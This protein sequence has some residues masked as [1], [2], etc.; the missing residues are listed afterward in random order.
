MNKEYENKNR[1]GQNVRYQPE[2]LSLKG[3]YTIS[4]IS[5]TIG[6]VIVGILNLATPLQIITDRLAHLSRQTGPF[7]LLNIIPPV[8]FLLMIYV[9]IRKILF[10]DENYL[11]YTLYFLLDKLIQYVT[12]LD[13]YWI[14]K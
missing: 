13:T 5:I 11:L 4:F 2:D 3:Y 9:S 1:P 7:F 12:V 14:E 8:L 10:P 6:F